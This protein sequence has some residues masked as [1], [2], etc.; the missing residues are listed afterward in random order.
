MTYDRTQAIRIIRGTLTNAPA[1]YDAATSAGL[2]LPAACALV[3]KET[4][5]R[6]VYGHD[7][8]GTFAGYP[9]TVNADNFDV[10]WWYVNTQ[11]HQSN[12]VGPVQLTA[13]GLLSDMLAK[14]L[15]PWDPMDNMA[16]GF[17][18]ILGY[19]DAAVKA[20]DAHPWVTAGTRYNGAQAYGLDLAAKVAAW[21]TLLAPAA[22]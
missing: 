17:A 19:H 22:I 20:G 8:G 18:L 15:K 12:G 13:R 1:L 11:G 5:G 9:G 6:N 7:V 4:G 10:F 2:T 3:Q 21:R 14:G 16:Y